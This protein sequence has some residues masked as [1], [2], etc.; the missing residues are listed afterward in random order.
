M[1]NL[2]PAPFVKGQWG[3]PAKADRLIHLFMA[4]IFVVLP[5]IQ[6]AAVYFGRQDPFIMYG[7][8]YI[9]LFFL[10][11]WIE[12]YGNTRF[13]FLALDLLLFAVSVSG[14][15]GIPF[16]GLG[17]ARSAQA[18]ILFM[19]F[20]LMRNFTLFIILPRASVVS[21]IELA[22]IAE[23]WLFRGGVVLLLS[24]FLFTLTQGA[25]IS[26]DRFFRDNW[27]H[28]NS[29]GMMSATVL[30][31]CIMSPHLKKWEKLLSGSLA[32]YIGLMMQSRAAVGSLILSILLITVIDMI[33]RKE[34]GKAVIVLT[35]VVA[36]GSVAWLALGSLLTNFTPIKAMIERTTTDDPT[37]GRIAMFKYAVEYF[38]KSPVFGYG[39]SNGFQMDNFLAKY[40]T[41][42]G[43]VGVVLYF[44]FLLTILYFCFRAYLRSEDEEHALIAKFALT[45]N[46][47][48]LVRSTAEATDLFHM[49]DIMSTS[50]FLWSAI[51]VSMARRQG[52]L[53]SGHIPEW[54]STDSI[55]AP[56]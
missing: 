8:I 47:F 7:V 32:L 50:A 14:M 19:I 5:A 31:L 45:F 27:I 33:R 30:V 3:A 2:L 13:S 1:A 49:S 18:T 53:E 56:E 35:S 54:K 34:K 26:K 21:Q 17:G 9:V 39:Y 41:E 28:P 24:T 42:T 40:A 23:K 48:V 55:V 38:E 10:A 29:V 46:L 11:M 52:R 16:Q 12:S 25:T 15:F 36:V 4:V 44:A 6:Y 22:R 43:L 20:V 37:A 51:I